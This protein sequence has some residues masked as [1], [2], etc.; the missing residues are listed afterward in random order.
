MKR[1]VFALVASVVILSRCFSL[2]ADDKPQAVAPLKL[3]QIISREDP[4]FNCAS[5]SL[6]IGRDGMVYLTSAGHDSGYILRVSRDGRDKLGGASIEAIHNAAA[7]ASGLIATAHGH[8]ARQVAIYDKEFRKTLAVTDFLV[9]DQVGWDAPGDVEAGASGDFYGLDQHRDRILELNVDGKIVKAYALPHIDKCPVQAFRVCEKAQAFYMVRWGRP[10]V[11]CLGFDG[12]VK[13]ERSLGVS[14]NTYE[15]DNG[16]FDVDPDGVLYTIGSQE[17]VLRKTGLDGKP[18][19]EIRLNIPPERKLAEGIRGMRF[20]GGEAFL[21]GRHPTELFQVYDLSTGALKRSVNIDHERLTVTTQGGPWI[22][23]EAVDFAIEFDGGGRRITPRWR[24]WARPFGVLDYRELKLAGGKLLLPEDL[25]GFYQIKVT[26]ESTPWQ[27]GDTASEYK[28]QTL[29]EVRAAGARGSAAA[30]T[31]LGR[32]HFG[33]GEEIP[34]AVYLRGNAPKETELTITLRDGSQTLATAKARFNPAAK[35]IRFTLPKSLTNRLRPGKYLLDVRRTPHAAREAGPTEPHAERE[36]YNLTCVP[37][38]L[39]IGPGMRPAPLLT[40]IYGDYRCTYP[41]ASAWDAPD[42]ATASFRRSERL[43]FNLMVDHLG[44]PDQMRD[45]SLAAPR[46]EVADLMK[47]L[48]AD[49]RAV[50]PEKLV[51]AP[52]LLQAMSGYS[53]SGISQMAIL[54]GNDAGLPLGGPG[55]DSRTPE[56]D[57]KDLTTTTEALKGYPAF[58]GWSWASNWW[59]FGDRGAAAA[60][61]AEEKAACTAALKKAA[62]TGAWDNVLDKVTGY[63]LSYAVDA[64]AMFNKK[65][66]ELAPD[67]VTAV[68][69]PFRNVE[70]YPPIT[71]ANVD[72]SDLQAQWEQVELPYHGPFGVDFYKRP[73]KRAW[74]HPEVW[75]DAGTGDQILTTLWQMVM[76]GADGVGCS[77][78]VPPWHF[79]LKGNTDDPRMSSNGTCS[80]YRSLNAVLKPYGPWLVS[81]QNHDKV[82]IVASGRM[83]KID[84]WVGATGRHFARVME[85]YIACLHAHRP[86][87]IVFAEDIKPDTLK[88]YEALL[89]VGQ[90]VEM[91]PVLASALKS[92]RQSGVAVFADGTC[93]AE[94]VKDFVP[95]GLSF[96]HLEKDPSLAADDHAFWRTAAYAKAAAPELAKALAKVR[97]AAE[98]ENP[99]VFV[100]ERRAEDGRYLFL[101]NNTTFGDLEPGHLWRV[102]LACASLVPQVVPLALETTEGRAVYDVFAGKQVEP[103]GG[104]LQADCRNMPARVFAILPAAI[105]RVQVKGPNGVARGEAMRW[106]VQVQDSAGKAIAAAVPVR[107][108][109]LAADGG[110]LDQQYVSVASH[111]VG[112]EFILPLGAPGGQVALEAVELLSGKAATLDVVVAD[113]KSVPLDLLNLATVPILAERK[114]GRPLS[115]DNSAASDVAVGDFSPA[116]ESFGPHVRDLVVTEGGKL[117]VM[118]TMNWDHNLYAVDVETGAIRWRQRAGHY[119]AFEPTALGSGVAVQGF[120]MRSAQG[121]HLYL[122]GADGR[123]QRRFALYGLPQRLPHRFVPALVRDHVNSFAVGDGGKWVASAGDLGV[124]VWSADGRVLWQQDW[125]QRQRHSGKLL[126][127]DAAT[128]LVIEGTVATAYGATDG[129]PKWRQSVGR[130]G[131][132]R[133]ARTS[134]DAKT[135]VLYN[136]ADGGKMFVLGDGKIVR[137]IPTAAEDFSLSADGSLVAVVTEDLLKLYSVADGLQWVFH[138]DDLLHSPRFSGDGRLATA[139]NL[140]TAYVTDLEGRV[141]LEKDLKALA[142]PAW[143][144]DG[145][146]LLATWEGTV[147]RLDKSYAPKWQTRLTPEASDIRGKILADDG[148]PTTAMAG[149][150][151]AAQKPADLSANLLAKTTPMIRLVTSQ[152]T[153]SLTD[154]PRQKV[155][156][157]YDGKTDAPAEPWIPWHLVGTFAETSPLNYILIDAYRTQMKVAGVTLVEDPDHPESWLRDASIDYWDAAKELWV[158]MQPLRS[159]SAVHTHMFAKPV[160]AARFRLVLPWGVCGNTRLAEIVFHGEVLGCSHPDAVAKRPLAILFDEQEDIKQDLYADQGLA[161]SLEGAYSGGRCLTLTP[162]AGG[163]AAAG[164]PWREQF[165]ETVRNWDFEIVENPRP[166]QYRWLQFAWKALSPGTKGMT[167]KVSDGGYGGYAIAAGEPTAWEGTTIVKKVDAPSSAWQIVRVDLWAAAKKPWRVRS[168]RLGVKG[169]GAAFDQIVLGR[170]EQDLPAEK[171]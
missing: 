69:C 171:R 24:V 15:G 154:T 137:V 143:L 29:V 73:G 48:E 80:V 52:S 11:Q 37:Q 92:A 47:S 101:V 135:C 145:S 94:L 127:L 123:L 1:Q 144:A 40:M 23:G 85:A 36:Q 149:W 10:E 20:W 95:L 134:A 3:Q 125:F 118:N 42:I 2:A 152:G 44:Y 102:T 25:A 89:V 117:A 91:E 57:L 140:G 12:K 60:K 133:I 105:V 58:R 126:A 65:L 71:L 76:R 50:S 6:S 88:R 70:S 157:L 43:G 132:V 86:A 97:P 122:V 120:D 38:P 7:D 82:A 150:G 13:W 147:C 83:Y 107:V 128:L 26:P 119:F 63:R 72:E 158:P 75:N 124:A 8:F 64:Q 55:F 62:A 66:R 151:N 81:L 164:Q 116:D 163:Q 130:S 138:G 4:L 61:T 156:M 112:G 79:A 148:A 21:R 56:Q 30:A 121:Y 161:I 46:A 51:T 160:E 67:R 99:E 110:V 35:E 106:E 18:A 34:L 31:A 104:T 155:A 167:L 109:L 146:L 168:L 139:S 77:D 45:F 129:A 68:A 98:V 5:A 90:T 159:D 28:V 136:I 84:D 142:V 141:L 108:R 100:T 96:D 115:A 131:E 170:T 19:G 17:S 162:P 93:R 41:Q 153:T 22:A 165:G 9:S 49:P 16:G 59:V 32:V 74:G 53:A 54:M 39:V 114:G 14:S 113:A 103:A 27:H 169:G 33:R 87:S 78:P 166:G 111:G